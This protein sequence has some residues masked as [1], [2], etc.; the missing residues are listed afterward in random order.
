MAQAKALAELVRAAR[1][2]RD[3][4]VVCFTGYRLERLRAPDAPA[5]A[6]DLLDAIDV[7]IDGT[8]LAA[9]NDGRGL[10]GSDNQRIH[11]LTDRYRDN[12][13]DFT[14]RERDVDIVVTERAAFLVGVPTKRVLAA[15]ENATDRLAASAASVGGVQTGET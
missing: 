8:Y 1:V 15:F 4:G 10:R 14:G 7:L 13:Y 12:G 5:G 2:D 3:L 6:A 11:Y 9:R